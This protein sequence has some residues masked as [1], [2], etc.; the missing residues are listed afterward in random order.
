MLVMHG[1]YLGL[2]IVQLIFAVAVTGICIFGAVYI[3]TSGMILNIVT[4]FATIVTAIYYFVAYYAQPGMYQYWA[5]LSLEIFCLI[6][7][8][9]SFADLAAEVAYAAAL[10]CDTSYDYYTDSYYSTGCSSYSNAAVGL[11]GGAAGMGA[12]EL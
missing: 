12:L 3:P 7:W 6:F 4:G 9:T 5:I 11:F 8:L 2:R 10:T 1:A